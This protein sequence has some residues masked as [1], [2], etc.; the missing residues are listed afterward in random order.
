M[1]AMH[2]ALQHGALDAAMDSF[3]EVVIFSAIASGHTLHRPPN[4]P[5]LPQPVTSKPWFDSACTAARRH[6][7]QLY[8]TLGQAHPDVMLAARSYHTMRRCKQ[9]QWATAVVDDLIQQAVHQPKSFW[10]NFKSSKSSSPAAS[11]ASDVQACIQY[12]TNLLHKPH[13]PGT[14][15]PPGTILDHHDHVLNAAFTAEE[16]RATLASL[17]N[18]VA[19]GADGIPAEFYKYA[20][21]TDE[22]GVVLEHLLVDYLTELFNCFFD[23]GSL[24]RKWGT[25]LLTLLF[26]KGDKSNWA[27]YRPLAVTLVIAKVYGL[28]LNTRLSKWAEQNHIHCPAQVGFRPKHSTVFNNFVLQHFVQKQ[29]H[30]RR[31]LFVYFLDI[32]KAYDTVLR[33][34][35]WQRLHH[36]GVRGR[37]LFALSA[38]YHHVAYIVKFQNGTAAPFAC[39]IGVR[40]G[41]PVSPFLF[42]VI[43]EQL[44]DILLE[45]CPAAG[46]TFQVP[47]VGQS[48]HVPCLMFADDSAGMEE[49]GVRA[50]MA[51]H[52][53]DRF[54][55]NHDLDLS[56]PKTKMLV[57]NASFQTTVDRSIVFTFRGQ[58]VQRTTEHMFLGLL[59]K[60][61]NTIAGMLQSAVRR[62]QAALALVYRKIHAHG[63][64][65]NAN[66]ML[67]LFNAVVLPNLTFGCEVWG[68]WI[69]HI[70]GAASHDTWLHGFH[71]H[72]AQNVVD[73]VRMAF[74]RTLL[75]LP[76]GTPLWNI[77]RE[78][79]WYPLQV[80]VARQLVKFMNKLWDLP[81]STLARRAMLESWQAF[82]DGRCPDG[83]C[84]RVHT[85]L[86]AAGVPPKDHLQE[87][88]R[89]P[90][91]DANVV[92]QTLRH[93]CHQV[94]MLPGLTSKLAAYHTDFA[95]PLDA[96]AR[97]RG[98]RRAMHLD[99]PLPV[100]KVKLLTRFRLS[101]HHLAVETGRWSS[102]AIDNRTCQLCR[103]GAVQDEHHILFVCS[104]I[105]HVR[106]R[107]PVLFGNNRFTHVRQLMDYTSMLDW[108]DVA[109]DMC[110]F[111]HEIGGIYSP[112]V[113]PGLG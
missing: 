70:D 57:F 44:H 75:G 82:L 55:R 37:M 107:Y 103:S 77:L 11:C 86:V 79:G 91:Y 110:R 71:D 78:L 67:R 109:R 7:F 36:L 66:V 10:R 87:D 56:L 48:S 95:L 42:S 16:V 108:R 92:W 41:C 68:P 34:Q 50:Q 22:R 72:P 53:V 52:S 62:G 100:H 59:T 113:L 93:A 106:N 18:N 20:V 83:W 63:A 47:L 28:L 97:R 69:L 14:A 8:R 65:S 31:P 111:L 4:H 102:V 112:I 64:R 2:A 104:A 3:E 5:Q 6:Y 99:L 1:G 88:N 45:D 9:R 101:C 40:Q 98:W 80:Y 76:S 39:N 54:C 25:S 15:P 96:R 19:A 73:Q 43:I 38:L 58:V 30:L 85:F 74:A 46:P 12:L 60:Q 29:K 105:L 89:I 90:R 24:P 51:L 21:H 49:S 23:K 33:A 13:L 61:K 26:K 81:A 35:V 94:Y 84:A 32:S 17:R 27:N